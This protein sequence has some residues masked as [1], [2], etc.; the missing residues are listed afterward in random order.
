MLDVIAGGEASGPFVP[1]LPDSS[2][3]SCV[4]TDPGKL[5]IGVRV[6]SAINP[7]PDPEAYAAVDTAV[8]V[9]TDWDTTSTSCHRRRSTTPRSP[10]SSC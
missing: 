10:A 7:T 9:L 2:F 1:G 4:G 3:A 8:R 6:P 5:R